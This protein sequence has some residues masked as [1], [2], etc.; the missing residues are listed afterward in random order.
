MNVHN[1]DDLIS[2]S[3]N[4]MNQVQSENLNVLLSQPNMHTIL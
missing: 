4:L 1:I 2:K 3:L